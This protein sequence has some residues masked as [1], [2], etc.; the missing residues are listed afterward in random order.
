MTCENN[1]IIIELQS[2]E[3]RNF[4]MTIQTKVG[5]TNTYKPLNL[6][7][8]TIEVDI[9]KYPYFSVD[10]IIH[11]DLTIEEPGLVDSYILPQV[12][13]TD[14][15]QNTIGKFVLGISQEDL[16]LLKPEGEYYLIITLVNGDTR[17][18]ISGEGDS[19]GILRFCNS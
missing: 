18:I 16:E 6:T 11:K 8:Y 10:S 15:E 4:S 13:S 5:N 1:R 12:Q 9:K 3:V 2:G 19:S 17:I 14:P 7:E